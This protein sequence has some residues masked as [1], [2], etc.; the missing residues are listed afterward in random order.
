MILVQF[1]NMRKDPF[2]PSKL[3]V[4]RPNTLML[5]S[6]HSLMISSAGTW[7]TITRFRPLTFSMFSELKQM[8]VADNLMACL[9]RYLVLRIN[10]VHLFLML[11]VIVV[12]AHFIIFCCHDLFIKENILW[13]VTLAF[14]D[15][16]VFW[17][18]ISSIL[19]L[20]LVLQFLEDIKLVYL[21]FSNKLIEELFKP[22]HIIFIFIVNSWRTISICKRFRKH[23]LFL[24][25]IST[26]LLQKL[27]QS[28]ILRRPTTA[29]KIILRQELY[30]IGS[31]HSLMTCSITAALTH[32]VFK[33]RVTVLS[34]AE[35]ILA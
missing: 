12:W 21:I 31:C 7:W 18:D 10:R 2:L 30:S 17:G 25:E 15:K 11:E 24:C 23:L 26:L 4:V 33:I 34:L 6:T 14:F 32:L 8:I 19:Q 22:L 9:H 35:Q 27:S 3:I 20:R 5:N 29:L 28:L 13:G 1:L 16:Y